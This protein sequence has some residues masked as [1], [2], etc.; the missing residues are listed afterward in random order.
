MRRV[1]GL[2]AAGMAS[3]HAGRLQPSIMKRSS[4]FNIV[5]E[6]SAYSSIMRESGTSGRVCCRIALFD[7]L[8]V[9]A[10]DTGT[11]GHVDEVV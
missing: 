8:L 1:N 7:G 11:Q 9:Y 10:A 3:H 6:T 4:L 2:E 5:G